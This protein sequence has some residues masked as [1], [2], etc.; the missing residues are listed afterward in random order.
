MLRELSLLRSLSNKKLMTF[1]LL[2]AKF[3]L[4]LD[5]RKTVK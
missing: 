2:S 5:S 3:L 4:F 1:D